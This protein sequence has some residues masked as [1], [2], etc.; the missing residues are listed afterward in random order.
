VLERV[1]AEVTKLSEHLPETMLSK[2][3]ELTA[4]ERRLANFVDFIGEDMGAKPSPMPSSR[5]SAGSRRSGR[6]WR[7]SPGA[8]RRCSRHRPWSGSRSG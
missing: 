2:E 5:R 4:E 3:S 6:S 8:E 1:E 7:P